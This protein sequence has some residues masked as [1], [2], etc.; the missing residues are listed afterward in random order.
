MTDS[1]QPATLL[2]A[3]PFATTLGIELRSATKEEVRGV[4]PWKEEQCTAGGVTHGGALMSLADTV[5]AI[6]AFLN[7]S[8]GSTTSTIESK[9][10]FFRPVREGEVEAVA[11]PLRAGRMV[12]VVQTDLFSDEGTRVPKLRRPRRCLR[13]L[14]GR[15][16]ATRR[17]AA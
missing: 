1:Q 7:L 16:A 2:E 6:C 4:L 5:G 10:N 9:T 15:P 17:V 13:Q 3:I 8:P 14:P 12:I 11:R